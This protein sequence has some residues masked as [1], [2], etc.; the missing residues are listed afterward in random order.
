MIRVYSANFTPEDYAKIA[1]ILEQ[2]LNA[3]CP[4]S[5]CVN[6]NTCIDCENCRVCKA[7]LPAIHY[8]AEHGKMVEL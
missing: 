1:C 8:C 7:V 4:G 3:V 2:G 5:N 6:V